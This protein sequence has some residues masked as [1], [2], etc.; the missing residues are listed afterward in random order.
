MH[1]M[2]AVVVV[3]LGL[4]GC[5][6]SGPRTHPVSG[7]VVLPG[8]DV[9]HL[10]GSTVE[11]VSEADPAVRASGEVRPDGRF[12]LETLHEGVIKKGALEGAYRARLVLP[13]DDPQVK[14]QA[15][16]AID[17]RFTQFQTAGLSVTV[18]AAGDVTLTVA[19]RAK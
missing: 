15:A 5:G 12:T 11:L 1:R 17:P 4:T 19:P 3:V 7:T 6:Q 18:P 8:G 16:R 2:A 9:S 14:K 10:A 13:D